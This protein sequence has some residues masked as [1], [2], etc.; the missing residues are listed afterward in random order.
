S[1]SGGTSCCAA[2]GIV[3][4]ARIR[5]A[6]GIERITPPCR[7]GAAAASGVGGSVEAG[8]VRALVRRV[9]NSIRLHWLRGLCLL[10]FPDP[11]ETGVNPMML[12]RIRANSLVPAIAMIA[13]SACAADQPREDAADLVLR[14]GHIVTVDS[15][16]PEAEAVAIRGYEIVAVGSNDEIEAYIGNGTRGIDLGGRLA[17]PG[18]IEGHG[19][20]MGLGNAKM[21]LDLTTV[22]SWEEIVAMVGAA[23]RDAGRDAWISG[24]GW[25]QEKWDS[26]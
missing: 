17:I 8:R 26:V 9:N 25:H 14:N 6:A 24:R 2:T 20:Y 15:T 19:H 3:T 1:A 7:C 11:T 13:L 10:S 5:D 4:K 18:F 21:I 16:R 22:R 23:A 12:G